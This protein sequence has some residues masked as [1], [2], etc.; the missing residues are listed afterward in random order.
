MTFFNKLLKQRKNRRAK[1]TR[2]QRR[3]S[4]EK[5][6]DRR[7]MAADVT[8]MDG[9]LEIEGTD[10]DDSAQVAIVDEGNT[11]RV[12]ITDSIDAPEVYEFVRGDVNHIVFQGYAGNDLFD[13]DT[14]IR[15]IATGGDDNDILIGGSVRDE[16]FAGPGD[17][18]ILGRGGNDDLR[19]GKGNDWVDGGAGKDHIWG[20]SGRD[21]LRGGDDDD[22]IL[23]GA[24]NDVVLG[25]DGNDVV[26]GQAGYDIVSGG[27][28]VDVVYGGDDNDVVMGGPGFDEVRGGRGADLYLVQE[29]DDLVGF[30]D[31]EDQRIDLAETDSV[32]LFTGELNDQSS[33]ASIAIIRGVSEYD[34][35]TSLADV[36]SLDDG[37]EPFIIDGDAD[38]VSLPDGSWW[39]SYGGDGRTT[40]IGNTGGGVSLN[41]DPDVSLTNPDLVSLNEEADTGLTNPD[42]DLVIWL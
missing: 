1:K 16:L 18:V 20:A 10:D 13:N 34:P 3:L 22:T 25:N 6:E 35:P 37:M 15:S 9:V 11:V 36:V 40:L 19:A 42:A 14:D 7:L 4:I 26:S 5:V 8:L 12:R 31:G 39:V 17:D 2:Q 21:I 30:A 33:G 29:D 41:D 28:G 23:A 32:Y 24:G 38:L 27:L